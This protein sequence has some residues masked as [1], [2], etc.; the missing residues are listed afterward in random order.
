[1]RL[2]RTAVLACFLC[3]SA[4][5][6]ETQVSDTAA[7]KAKVTAGPQEVKGLVLPTL[8]DRLVVLGVSIVLSSGLWII[9]NE[10]RKRADRERAG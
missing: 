2:L 6:G 9:L 8:E 7:A 5:V 10:K 1:M 4:A 3:L